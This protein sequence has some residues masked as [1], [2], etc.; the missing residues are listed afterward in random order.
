[1]YIS[2]SW[3]RKSDKKWVALVNN[4]PKW[5]VKLLDNEKYETHEIITKK[6]NPLLASVYDG[7]HFY[8]D[9]FNSLDTVKAYVF[10]IEM[11]KYINLARKETEN[12]AP[13][14]QFDYMLKDTGEIMCYDEMLRVWHEEYDGDD[15]TNC[16][17]WSEVFEKVKGANMSKTREDVERLKEEWKKDG[18]WDICDTEGFEEYRDELQQFQ[19]D[20]EKECEEKAKQKEQQKLTDSLRHCPMARGSEDYKLCLQR[21]CAWWIGEEY[22]CAMKSMAMS[23]DGIWNTLPGAG[24]GY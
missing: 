18:C 24:R 15:D 23:L 10:G 11:N 14:K 2:I 6:S 7:D 17:H 3:E 13:G 16:T 4:E 9:T 5:T 8:R 21:D 22:R 12:E 1:M 20:C 19:E